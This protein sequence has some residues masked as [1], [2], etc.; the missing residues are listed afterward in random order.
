MKNCNK[1]ISFVVKEIKAKNGNTYYAFGVLFDSNNFY[2]IKF[3]PESE[4]K[5]LVD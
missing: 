2:L 3:I 5:N 1:H 4:Y